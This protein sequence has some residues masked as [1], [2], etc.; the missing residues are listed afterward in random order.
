MGYEFGNCEMYIRTMNLMQCSLLLA[1]NFSDDPVFR[2]AFRGTESQR[3]RAMESYF[4]A[5]LEYCLAEGNILLAPGNAGLAAWI[6]EKAF[7]PAIDQNRIGSQPDYVVTGWQKLV[8]HQLAALDV[9]KE[10]GKQFGFCQVL[11]VDF[12]IRR[13]GYGQWLMESCLEQMAEAGLKECWLVTENESNQPFLENL[14]FKKFT[15]LHQP[16]GPV[17]FVCS[18]VIGPL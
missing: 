8:R 6:P 9:V 12:S 18:K 13:R 3:H 16:G 17:S 1:S 10:N 7:P 14:G 5:Q 4:S 11:A 2:Y 15:T